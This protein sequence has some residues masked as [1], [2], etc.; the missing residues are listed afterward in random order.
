MLSL[1][2]GGWRLLWW[3]IF[4][5]M[6]KVS[7]LVIWDKM[8]PCMGQNGPGSYRGIILPRSPKPMALILLGY[9]WPWGVLKLQSLRPLSGV[10]FTERCK[11][12]KN[13]IADNLKRGYETMSYTLYN[14][15]SYIFIFNQYTFYFCSHGFTMHQWIKLNL[16]R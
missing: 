3:M 7:I 6:L 14:T 15:A 4:T 11:M 9:H 2:F 12:I 5:A 1:L 13:L 10:I 16:T 8:I